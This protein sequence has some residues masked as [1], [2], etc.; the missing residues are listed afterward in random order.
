MRKKNSIVGITPTIQGFQDY[1]KHLYT[2]ANSHHNFEY[3]YSY[4]PRTVGYLFKSITDRRVDSADFI[5]PIS[6]LFAIANYLDGNI[7]D[8]VIRRYPAC[9][10]YCLQ[11]PCQCQ[12]THKQPPK[13]IPAYRVLDELRGKANSIINTTPSITFEYFANNTRLIYPNNEIIWSHAGPGFHFAKILEE[14]AEI[15]EAY[16][17]Y[18]K[19]EK[20]KEAVMSEVSDVFAWLISA[21]AIVFPEHVY[22]DEIKS[23]YLDGCPVC[24]TDPCVCTPYGSRPVNLIEIKTLLDVKNKLDDLATLVPES[25]SQLGEIIRSISVSVDNQDE[26][27][28]RLSLAQAKDILGGIDSSI[29]KADDIGKRTASLI[30]SIFSIFKMLDI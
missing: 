16:S 19:G 15:H 30:S 28:A 10:P 20:N 17:A 4:L 18:R 8:A 2:L 21:W 13:Y 9:C 5:K 7:E 29:S 25:Q 14:I 22:I 6:W 12:R 1:T 24:K 23:Y 27:T 3:L 11:A 26:P